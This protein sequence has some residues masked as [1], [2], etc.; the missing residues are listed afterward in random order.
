MTDVPKEL[1]V[2]LGARGAEPETLMLISAPDAHG[3]VKVRRWTASNWSAP[4][5][6]HEEPARGLLAWID[7]QV[8]VGRS[9][10]QSAYTVHLWLTGT[11]SGSHGW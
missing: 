5:P 7:A 11:G 8:A 3:R 1:P 4:A 10:N 2:L 9:M 6:A